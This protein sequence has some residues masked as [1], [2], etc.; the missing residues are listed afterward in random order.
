MITALEEA[1]YTL[2]LHRDTIK[3]LGDSLR[4]NEL[5]ENVKKLEEQT[6]EQDFWANQENSSK[7]LQTIKQ[8]KDKIEDFEALTVRLE[9]AIT[10]AEMAIEENDE[11]SIPEVQAEL[12]G[13]IEEEERM[14]LETLLCGEYDKNNAI[15]SFHPGA[16]GTEAQDWAQMLYRMITRWAESHKFTVKLMDWLDGDEAGIKSAT[17]MVIGT[18]AYGYLKS[19]NGVHR[20]VRIS[21]FDSSG[22]RHTSFSSFEVMP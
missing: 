8:T 16:G 21:P 1:R 18:N 7:V 3:E 17:I 13:I 6:Q 9:D 11:G 10:L 12:A 14:R 22:R 2:T 5:R 20:L 4:I 15:V 19:E